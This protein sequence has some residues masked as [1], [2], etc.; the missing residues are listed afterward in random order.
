[1]AT[2]NQEEITIDHIQDGDDIEEETGEIAVD[3][4][5]TEKEIM[6]ISPVSGVSKDDINIR[7]NEN[8][9]IISG[10]RYSPPTTG[11]TY[12]VK[13]CFWGKFSRM[14]VLPTK[15]DVS[16]VKASFKNGILIITI[17]V[18]FEPKEKI[19]PIQEA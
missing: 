2:T 5:K 12:V 10:K 7:I 4:Y 17:P 6:I 16:H 11:G 8:I 14:V 15:V 18:I 19:V 3:I 13:E 9:L 1:M